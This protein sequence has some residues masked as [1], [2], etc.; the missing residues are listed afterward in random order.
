MR[1][2]NGK[3]KLVKINIDENQTLASQLRVQS[4]PTVYAFRDGRPL[5]GFQGAQPESAIKAF[6]ERLLGEEAAM[7]AATAIDAADKALEAGDLQ[8]AAEVYAAVL[9]QDP[10]NVAA[11]AGLARC[12]L[13]SGDTA[14]AEQTLGLVPPDKRDSGPVASVRAA[15][16]LAKMAGKA[17]DTA[18]LEAKVEAEPANH[19]ARIDYAM[20]LAAGGKKSEAL[21]Q[22]LESRPPRPQMERGGGAQAAGAAVRGLGA[23]GR[24]HPGGPPAP[25]VDPVLLTTD[26]RGATRLVTIAERYRSPADLPQPSPV[27]PLRRA[28]LLPRAMLP[29]NVFEPRYLAMLDDVM[30]TSRVLAIVQPA[31]GEGRIAAGQVGRAAPRRLRRPRHRLSGAGRRAACHLAHRHRPL[32]AR[33]RGRHSQALSPLPHEL[34]ALPRRFPAAAARTRSTARASSTRS[35]PIWT[36]TRCAPTGRRS[37]RPPTSG[38]STRWPSSPPTARRRSRP[39]SRPRPED[40]SR[41]AGGAGRDGARPPVPAAARAPPCNDGGAPW[42]RSRREPARRGPARVDA[43]LLEILVCPRTKTSLVYDEARQELISRAA[44]L[45]FPIRDGIPIMLEEEARQLDDD[46]LRTLGRR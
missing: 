37:P 20:A 7:D 19:Q 5:D 17:G 15:L 32:H 36:P 39:C 35:R 34:R 24:G 26:N 43:R 25:V 23:E 11:L 9:Q 4:I 8:A 29:L 22:L 13:K 33:E 44:R 27:F 6:V 28:I 16:D 46:E 31:D 12:Y 41:G 21:D 3:V 18:K 2:Q 14:R 1:A 42:L 40:P 45:A 10:Q 30:S 38:W